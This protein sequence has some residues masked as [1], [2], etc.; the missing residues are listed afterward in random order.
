MQPIVQLV[1]QEDAR[2]LTRMSCLYLLLVVNKVGAGSGE[3]GQRESKYEDREVGVC[4][5]SKGHRQG[6]EG[7]WEGRREAEGGIASGRSILGN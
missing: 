2:L 5:A 4:K 3:R 1:S 6:M 7:R